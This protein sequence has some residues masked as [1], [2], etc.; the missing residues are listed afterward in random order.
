MNA[1][2]I[3]LQIVVIF[4]FILFS[5]NLKA[6]NNIGIGLNLGGGSIGGNLTTL[7]GFTSGL[8]VEGNPGFSSNLIFRLSFIYIT[9]SNIL[10]PKN[11]SR[12]F[13]FIKGFTL[14]GIESQ[15]IL[16]NIYIEEGLGILI[17]NDRTFENINVW[18]LGA[19]F[20]VLPGIDFRDELNKGFK[21]GV[22][23]EYGLTFTNT[24]VW[25]FSVHL[26]TEYY[27]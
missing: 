2:K 13:P 21:L 12:N 3:Y 25:Y 7:V 20:S 18:D 5:S 17:L 15:N 10:F 16:K 27:F 22:G 26:Q 6:Q 23:T 14:K 24:N 1:R 19:A 9:D 4:F 8:F 11:S